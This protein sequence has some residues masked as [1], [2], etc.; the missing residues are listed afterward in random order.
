MTT[1]LRERLGQQIEIESTESLRR[2]VDELTDANIRYQAENTALARELTE[3]REHL[4]DV[5]DDLATRTS[6]RHMIREKISQLEH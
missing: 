3:L 1:V 4:T 6:L 5:E 2:R